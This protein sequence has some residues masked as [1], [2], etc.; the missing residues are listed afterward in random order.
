[1]CN[2]NTQVLFIDCASKHLVMK[3]QKAK[4]NPKQTKKKTPHKIKTHQNKPQE[5]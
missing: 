1:M 3:S 4:K 5:N 2:L